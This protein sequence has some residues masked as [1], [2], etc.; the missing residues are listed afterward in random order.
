MD[1]SVYHLS[2]VNIA[3]TEKKSEKVLTRMATRQQPSLVA[4]VLFLVPLAPD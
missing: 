2:D 4:A 3:P 1:A